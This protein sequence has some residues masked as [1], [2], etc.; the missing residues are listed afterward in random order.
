M[1][2]LGGGRGALGGCGS[3]AV[4]LCWG[5]VG[6]VGWS[7]KVGSSGCGGEKS[8]VDGVRGP[9]RGGVRLG[10]RFCGVVVAG[11]CSGGGVMAVNITRLGQA[12]TRTRRI[13][14]GE[15][16]RP[17]TSWEKRGGGSSEVD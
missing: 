2:G 8:G 14:W 5:G 17:Q 15:C 6:G 11:R 16:K 9:A 3:D 1:G 7:K 4:V 12:E 10:V 13:C